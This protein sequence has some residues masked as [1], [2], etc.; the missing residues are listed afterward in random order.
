[1]MAFLATPEA[2]IELHELFAHRDLRGGHGALYRRCRPT[3]AKQWST[4]KR[5]VL[6]HPEA[7]ADFAVKQRYGDRGFGKTRVRILQSRVGARLR[8]IVLG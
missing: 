1:M 8:A 2:F 7:A 6:D 3:I 4:P 5:I